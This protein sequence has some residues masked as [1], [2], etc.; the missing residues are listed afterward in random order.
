MLPVAKRHTEIAVLIIWA[1]VGV[2][3]AFTAGLQYEILW[4]AAVL[5]AALWAICG[6]AL[7]AAYLWRARQQE[8]RRRNLLMALAA[9]GFI[10]V[11]ILAWTPLER[12]GA[13]LLFQWRFMRMRTALDDLA[14]D[15]SRSPSIVTKEDHSRLGRYVVDAGPP[16]RYAV[17]L[18][19]GL[20]DNWCGIVHD[21]SGEV[22]Q[23]NRFYDGDASWE[24][25]VLADVK[26]LFGGDMF[27]CEHVESTYY[28]CC[29]T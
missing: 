28:R 10:A 3:L 21:P 4:V 16:L 11:L 2:V 5:P 12:G 22:L 23:V 19:G 29:F 13:G 8:S 18:P 26:K 1:L 27:W 9:P 17:P 15:L 7:S 14:A 6:L 24:D 25:P 20:I